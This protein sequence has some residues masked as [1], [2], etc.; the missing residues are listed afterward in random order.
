MTHEKMRLHLFG[1]KRA[2]Q[3]QPEL[4]K[5]KKAIECGLFHLCKLGAI[6]EWLPPLP[7]PPVRHILSTGP[8][9]SG[10]MCP[11]APWR[12][13]FVFSVQLVNDSPFWLKH[14]IPF[15]QSCLSRLLVSEQ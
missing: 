9:F 5:K 11:T 14:P 1:E 12:L 4:L 6:K 10:R 7:P 15:H 13:R 2:N 8:T 3:R